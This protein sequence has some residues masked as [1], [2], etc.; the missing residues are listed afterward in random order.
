MYSKTWWSSTFCTQP[1]PEG[2][3]HFVVFGKF[4]CSKLY[5]NHVYVID[6]KYN[7]KRIWIAALGC[8]CTLINKAFFC[9]SWVVLILFGNILKCQ[10]FQGNLQ[11]LFALSTRTSSGCSGWPF[12]QF[13]LT[14][15]ESNKAQNLFPMLVGHRTK[16]KSSDQI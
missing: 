13:I 11:V 9:N 1:V 3:V 16:I 6:M 2:L 5:A 10:Y 7:G 12:I 8:T 4:T 14:V 15:L